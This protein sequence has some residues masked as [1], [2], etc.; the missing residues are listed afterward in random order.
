MYRKYI[1]KFEKVSFEQYLK[2]FKNLFPFQNFED[3]NVINEVRRIYDNI[4]LPTRSDDGSAGYDFYNNIEIV[5]LDGGESIVVPTGIRCKMN[6]GWVLLLVPRSG[7]GF[8]YG[9]RLHNTI[10]VIDSSYYGADNEG[11]IMAKFSHTS[12][13]NKLSIKE[14]D[15]FMQG[16]FIPYGIAEEVK[17]TNKRTGGFGS[18]GK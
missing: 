18:S 2:D 15:R 17:P 14:G 4:K 12:A 5:E 9:F 1:A 3:E 6:K 10:G 11:H 7:L 8:K 16:I 13:D